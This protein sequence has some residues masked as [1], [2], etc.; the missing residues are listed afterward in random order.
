MDRITPAGFSVGL[1][2]I[3][4]LMVLAPA[5]VGT[6]WD[7]ASVT[8]SVP[9]Y[10]YNSGQYVNFTVT[11]RD[12]GGAGNIQSVDVAVT[13]GYGLRYQRW[14]GV[15][16]GTD[17]G[18]NFTW[19][20]PYDLPTGSYYARAYSPGGN[21]SLD[22]DSFYVYHTSPVS[23]STND[24]SYDQGETMR[25]SI[26]S[27]DPQ[28]TSVALALNDSKGKKYPVGNGITVTTGRTT[29]FN[30]T[31]PRSV[32]AGSYRIEV[33]GEGDMA[34]LDSDSIYI[35][36]LSVYLSADTEPGKY[37]STFYVPGET[38]QIVIRATVN[39]YG[40]PDANDNLT[41][42]LTSK[43]AVVQNW[44]RLR[45]DSGGYINVS[46]TIPSTATD[47]IYNITITEDDGTVR[48]PDTVRIQMYMIL[49][50]PER[51]SFV[52]GESA[53]VFYTV[54]SVRDGTLAPPAQGYWRLAD[55]TGATRDSGSFTNPSGALTGRLPASTGGGT[56]YYYLS[57]WYNDTAA[58][59][60][61]F[62]DTSIRA[63]ALRLSIGTDSTVYQPGGLVIVT[64]STYAGSGTGFIPGADLQNIRVS[65][66]RPGADWSPRSE[67]GFSGISTGATGTAQV[68]M[69]LST[70]LDDLTDFRVEATAAKAGNSDT[71][72]AS[73]T[74]RKSSAISVVLSTDRSA[75]VSGET[76]HIT[77]ATYAPNTTGELTYIF[78]VAGGGYYSPL[79]L[80][81]ESTTSPSLDYSIPKDYQGDLTLTV[82]VYGPNG[83]V[84]QAYL[85]VPVS[86][87]SIVVNADSRTY[88]ANQTVKFAYSYRSVQY[89]DAALYF[90]IKDSGG[91]IVSEGALPA[92][93]SGRF[94]FR[95]P[96]AASSR[97]DVSVFASKDGRLVTG[98]T[99]TLNRMESYTVTISMDKDTY[100]PG[101]G[102]RIHYKV[103][104]SPGAPALVGPIEVAY[105]VADSNRFGRM[106]TNRLEGDLTY[107][108]PRNLPEGT[109]L[110]QVTVQD[111]TGNTGQG[112]AY[113]SVLVTRA[114]LGLKF[115]TTDWLILMVAVV[116]VA[117]GVI[118]IAAA[119]R[120]SRGRQSPQR[121]EPAQPMVYQAPPAPK[122]LVQMPPPPAPQAP[123]A[124]QYTPQYG[125]PPPP[126]VPRAVT[127]RV[128]VC[129]ACS[130]QID[131]ESAPPGTTVRC[132]V[133]GSGMVV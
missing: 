98:E 63:G 119:R 45:T 40:Q 5:S 84:G 80:R 90:R 102:V 113:G 19:R 43:G 58:Q 93:G 32:P 109:A 13:D 82:S 71:S 87:G 54:K 120:A 128:V 85:R 91:S 21:L 59:R 111:I 81:M 121:T 131:I 2:T 114:P 64:F 33:Y 36:K 42:T 88:G 49:L 31:V 124:Q 34:L 50:T 133:C 66:K 104:R 112:T 99:L 53:T 55:S 11:G 47:G 78:T 1:G 7:P 127:G 48:V 57:V 4:L 105:G 115:T 110:I 18:K 118:G 39:Y 69:G 86:Y 12:Y 25:V 8:V 65:S 16:I 23:I 73:F 35:Y 68:V 132:P 56:A 28:I 125:A 101:D 26:S 126:P 117:V 46:W 15:P 37:S 3:A 75:Y 116:A 44:S 123:P 70:A 24:Y 20:I 94:S 30:W 129:P 74:V 97:Y 38:L 14:D 61:T 108:L 92:G 22:Y 67:Y 106:M 122:P 52:H 17:T 77:V 83:G 72:S 100:A 95:V 103:T 6:G 29:V 107:T 79:V 60:S 51:G 10:S 89:A 96:P 130:G 76:V 41:V 9:S 62:E 27:T